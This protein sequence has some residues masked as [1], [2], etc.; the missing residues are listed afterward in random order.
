MPAMI[1][2]GFR[3]RR[4]YEARQEMEAREESED[5]EDRAENPER[6]LERQSEPETHDT[7]ERQSFLTRIWRLIRG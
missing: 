1:T 7:S 3:K 4:D 2:R 6:P 5:V